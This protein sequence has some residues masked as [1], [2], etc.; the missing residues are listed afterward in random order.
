MLELCFFGLEWCGHRVTNMQFASRFAFDS[1]AFDSASARPSAAW[2]YCW[3]ASR[4]TGLLDLQK[5]CTCIATR[6]KRVFVFQTRFSCLKRDGTSL[7]ENG[8]GGWRIIFS[9]LRKSF[10]WNMFWD[11]SNTFS[12]F[13][14][15]KH[16][17][18][19]LIRVWEIMIRNCF[20]EKCVF[21]VWNYFSRLK[22]V[23]CS[24]KQP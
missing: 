1:A 17:W 19:V 9:A 5:T 21:H 18:N 24:L 6:L 23:Q 2:G 3:L 20:G 22:L 7:V 8:L 11:V 13:K 12:R 14:H 10:E 15:E 4:A 16:V